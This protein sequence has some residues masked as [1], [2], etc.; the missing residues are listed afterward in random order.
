MIV[1]LVGRGHVLGALTLV[2]AGGTAYTRGDLH[3]AQGLASRITTAVDQGRQYRGALQ[4]RTRFA[5]LVEGLDGIVWRPIR[6]RWDDL[7]SQ[8]AETILGHPIRQWLEEPD[9][10][11]RSSMPTIARRCCPCCASARAAGRDV[12][13]EYRMTTVDGRLIWIDNIVRPVAGEDGRVRRVQGLMLDVTHRQRLTEERDHLLEMAQA[14]RVEA[15]ASAERARFLSSASELLASSLDQSATL[16]SLVR[17]AVP[18]FADSCVVHLAEPIDGRRL[19]AAGEDPEGTGMADML[20]RLA[21]SADLQTLLPALDRV[22]EGQ[23]LLLSEIGP[24]WMESLAPST[25]WRRSPR[26][27]CR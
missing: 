21:T 25:S 17:L 2:R 4:A 27:S 14:A 22:K 10:G 8:R 18:D 11:T 15:E 1:P 26:W 19:H 12:R 13:L 5:G 7:V 24:D 16:D 9:S 20:E 23:P 6:P 3:A